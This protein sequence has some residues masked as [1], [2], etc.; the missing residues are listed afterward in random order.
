MTLAILHLSA[1]CSYYKVKAV[2]TTPET[3]ADH[4]RSFNEQNKYVI[5]HSANN[6][7]HLENINISED[8]LSLSGVIKA[9][10]PQH[11]TM[12]QSGS[13]KSFK[14]KKKK[15]QPLN[16]AHF[17]LNKTID[18]SIGD[19]IVIPF[20]DVNKVTV[21]DRDSGRE[22]MSWVFGSLGLVL[23]V[24]IA[25]AAATSCPFVYINNGES[26]Q[27]AGELYPG[28][29]TP[30]IQRDDYLPLPNFS[31]NDNEYTIKITNELKEIQHT[32]LAQLMVVEHE[33]NVSVLLDKNGIPFTFSAINSPTNVVVDNQR[34]DLAPALQKDDNEYR[35]DTSIENK[36]NTRSIELEFDKPED[37]L[38]GKLYITAKN[39]MWLDYVYGKFN[40]QFGNYFN[41]FQEDMQNEPAE[42]S[43]AWAEKQHIPLSVYVQSNNSWKLVDQINVVG[44][45]AMR[46]IVIPID[47]DNIKSDKLNIKLETGFMFWEVDY[48]GIDYSK[49]SPIT[50]TQ[51]DP[52]SAFDENGKDVTELISKADNEYLIQP[53]I[54]NEVVVKYKVNQNKGDLN[55]T[56]FLKNRGFYNYI[57]NYEGR[58][59]YSL[60]KSF[61]NDGSFTEFSTHKY[62][63]ILNAEKEFLSNSI[64]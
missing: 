10:E 26:F 30:N 52:F 61:Q 21:N 48:V 24:A 46:D 64:Q 13:K 11:Q 16:E 29:I 56:V 41:T 20:K 50:V 55:T 28:I 17:F 12:T 32:D 57:R 63:E 14:Y 7:W 25:V 43:L 58:P 5:L 22:V 49:N 37:V 8:D 40:K 19:N 18:A 62:H 27:F 51:I 31:P 23:V 59:D 2:N 36:N 6:Y 39:S 3:M 4:I 9:V 60:L 15:T 45:L 47:I 33:D 44:P 35:F 38:E 42:N 53:E 54:G 1:G 34:V